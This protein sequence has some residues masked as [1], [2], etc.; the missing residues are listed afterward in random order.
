MTGASLA[1]EFA[2]FAA[3][4][5]EGKFF[6][7]HEVLESLW[8]RT[9]DRGQQ[10]LIQAA[11]ALHHLRHG[12]LRGARTM[13]DRALPR[14]LDPQVAACP[15]DLHAVAQ[16]AESARAQIGNAPAEALIERRPR[17]PKP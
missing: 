2:E 8:V 10:G 13:I 3:C 9:R 6:R 7:A 14:L 12:N 1:S 15:F 17:L 11:V 16:F 4:W 5:N